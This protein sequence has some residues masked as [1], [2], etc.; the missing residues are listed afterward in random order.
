MTGR[1]NQSL[2][3]AVRVYCLVTLLL[4][5]SRP[6]LISA[7]QIRPV[8]SPRNTEVPFC[9]TV[10]SSRSWPVFSG[11][12]KEHDKLLL[13]A[14]RDD[15]ILANGEELNVE[16]LHLTLSRGGLLNVNA[17]RDTQAEFLLD[18]AVERKG[19]RVEQ[20]RLEIRLAPPDRP[21]SYVSDLLDDLIRIFWDTS[22]H[23]FRPVT[24]DS[25]DQYFRRLQAQGITRLIVWPS[26][27][28]VIADPQN[29]E[30]EHWTRFS[31]QAQAIL[32]CE[33]LSNSMRKTASLK[34]YEWQRM[35][36]RARMD[37][38]F[39]RMFTTSA[40]Q[41]GI[42]L[43]VSF[44]P[45]EAALT[46]YYEV[47]AFDTD[48]TWLWG[49]LPGATP[50]VNYRS[51]EVSFAHYRE[52]LRHLGKADEATLQSVEIGGLTDSEPLAARLQDGHSDFELVASP[53]PPLDEHSFVLHRQV[54]G[55]F[56]LVR[57]GTIREQVEAQWVR[58]KARFRFKDDRLVIDEFKVP[59][60]HRYLLLRS[61][62]EVGDRLELPVVPDVTLR[63]AA[64]NPLGRCNIFCSRN[65]DSPEARS[66]RVA[67]ITPDGLFRTEFQA[68]ESS[69]DL[70]RKA[71]AK[72]WRLG[73]GTLVIDRCDRWSVEMTDFNRPA[74]REAVIRE[75]TTILKYDAF[76]E[77]MINTRSHT[78]LSAS[79]GDGPDGIR[80]MAYYRTRGVNYYHY[81][82]DRAFAPL[83]TADNE[84][85]RSAPIEQITTWQQGEWQGPCQSANSP[86]IWRYQRNRAIANGV[87]ALLVD[88]EREFPGTRIRAVIPESEAVI[89]GTQNDLADMA[90][91]EGGVYGRDYYRHIRGSLNH[92]PA[93][94]EGMAMVDLSGLSVEPV[95]LGIRFAPD[96]GPLNAF[97]NRCT[98]DLADNRGSSYRGPRSF[99]YEAQETLRGKNFDLKRPR[100]EEIICELL[101]RK[102]IEEVLLYEA[103][104]WTYNLPLS[105]RNLY[106]YSF[107]D[108]CP[109]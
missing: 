69:I 23:R 7:D 19:Q 89:K 46:K 63:A 1:I 59:E 43:T 2:P 21:I 76:D 87:R 80:P 33:E 38:E 91:P 41:H 56:G 30:A 4:L 66:T 96:A 34:S 78:Q 36:M 42:R 65:G 81:G 15:S 31:Q 45:F 68:I 71:K 77:I 106:S 13:T 48:G 97:V 73:D 55:S 88:L 9:Y 100:R 67:G 103:A 16:G 85:I 26:A 14:R 8:L 86:Y 104:D 70:F 6:Q 54:D 49:F 92:I 57:Y 72:N 51:G 52:I 17:A 93:I 75:M 82:I 27:F 83:S 28:P 102:E 40:K 50:T 64:G 62:S 29:Y 5:S 95:F 11:E 3:K 20:Q 44:R 35:L 47:P 105:D 22:S 99:F 32:D 74:A 101:R 79:T 90:R 94:G 18:V 84:H 24:T 53:V 10:G 60:S 12:L 58:L 98:S 37:P 39:D 25:F 108:D 107:L 61:R 109:P